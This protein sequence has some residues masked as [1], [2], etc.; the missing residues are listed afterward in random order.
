MGVGR[1]T[2]VGLCHL[3]GAHVRCGYLYV[4][5]KTCPECVVVSVGLARMWFGQ[6]PRFKL[7]RSGNLF[8]AFN[9]RTFF[10]DLCEHFAFL[11]DSWILCEILWSAD[12]LQVQANSIISSFLGMN[13]CGFEPSEWGHGLLGSI[14]EIIEMMKMFVARLTNAGRRKWTPS[15][16]TTFFGRISLI[17]LRMPTR[18]NKDI[19]TEPGQLSVEIVHGHS[20]SFELEVCQHS[21]KS[22]TRLMNLTKKQIARRDHKQFPEI[23][24]H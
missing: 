3:F 19:A 23:K 2:P 5:A 8:M 14:G 11:W 24:F 22:H 16:R 9:L 18:W 20:I 10:Y 15:M 12:K 7:D 17:S 13:R 6:S 21:T 4:E 1:S